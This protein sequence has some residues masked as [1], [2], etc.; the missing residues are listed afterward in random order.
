[1]FVAN[2]KLELIALHHGYESEGTTKAAAVPNYQAASCSLDNILHG[3]D[4]FNLAIYTPIMNPT[5]DVLEL[6]VASIEGAS[7]V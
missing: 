4:L 5:T 6:Y 2:M 7:L 3:A 1:M